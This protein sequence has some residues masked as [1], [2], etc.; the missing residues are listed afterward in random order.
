M[1]IQDLIDRLEPQQSTTA[2]AAPEVDLALMSLTSLA[3]SA[4]RIADALERFDMDGFRNQLL[5]IAYQAG[6]NFR[7]KA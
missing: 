4:K 2:S 6:V 5:D 3:V 7:G 1:D